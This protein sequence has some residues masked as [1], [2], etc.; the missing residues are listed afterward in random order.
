MASKAPLKADELF[1]ETKRFMTAIQV[2]I[3]LVNKILAHERFIV[4][5]T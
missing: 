5:L 1:L 4:F 2:P 3:T